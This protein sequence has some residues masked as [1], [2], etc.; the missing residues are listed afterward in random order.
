M[1]SNPQLLFVAGPNGAGKSTFSKALSQPGAV[2]FDIDEVNAKIEAAS[3]G[4]AKKKLYEKGTEV[5]FKLAKE[6]VNK[7]Q[8]F[9]LETSFR[10][11]G[12]T[13][14]VAQF[15]SFGYTTSM[16]YLSLNGVKR[17]TD[18]VAQRVSRG[19][20]HVDEKNIKGNYTEGLQYL[21]RFGNQFDNLAIYD[22]SDDIGEPELLLKAEQ[23]RLTYLNDEPPPYIATV[24]TN[25]ADYYRNKSNDYHM[26]R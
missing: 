14:L 9:T 5:F 20:H 6:A 11:E 12:L 25:I 26:R 19:G 15:K 17:S 7:Q 4:I 23:Q 22:A 16:I 8:D 10:D 18:R 21:E 3:P 13:N 24:I 1:P 2:I